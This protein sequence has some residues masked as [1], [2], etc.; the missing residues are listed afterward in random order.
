MAKL[1]LKELEQQFRAQPDCVEYILPQGKRCLRTSG[2]W[3]WYA[4]KCAQA[5]LKP[6]AV[7]GYADEAVGDGFTLSYCEH[8]IILSIDESSDKKESQQIC[9]P[10]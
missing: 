3:N 8:D 5:G 6:K 9:T 1:T 4:L 2:N 7:E 10:T